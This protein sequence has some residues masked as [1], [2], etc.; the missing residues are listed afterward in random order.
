MA[1]ENCLDSAENFLE[2]GKN[3]I[4]FERYTDAIEDLTKVIEFFPH[5]EIYAE[6]LFMAYYS[7]GFAYKKLKKYTEA[8]QD[9]RKASVFNSNSAEVWH[10]LGICLQK[11]FGSDDAGWAFDLA[12]AIK[13]GYSFKNSF[14]WLYF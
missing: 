3:S 12:D 8:M 6:K 1:Q 9:F 4:I 7:R 13:N 10:N 11:L 5:D 2:R 14:K